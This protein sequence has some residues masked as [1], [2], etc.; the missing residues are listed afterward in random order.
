MKIYLVQLLVSIVQQLHYPATLSWG[1]R[2]LDLR[3]STVDI[4]KKIYSIC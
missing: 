4:F 2:W 1:R 3:G